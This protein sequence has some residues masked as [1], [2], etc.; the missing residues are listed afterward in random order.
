VVVALVDMTRR[1]LVQTVQDGLR[2]QTVATA[3]INL[4]QQ[5]R[6]ALLSLKF[7]TPIQQPSLVV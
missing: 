5:V 2:L 4:R 7:L 1:L 6:Q 3:Q